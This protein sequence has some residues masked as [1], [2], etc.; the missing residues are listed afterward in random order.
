MSDQFR[1]SSKSASIN[2][3]LPIQ[4]SVC[5]MMMSFIQIHSYQWMSQELHI[6]KI[7][8]SF[9]SVLQILGKWDTGLESI[10]NSRMNIIIIQD[11]FMMAQWLNATWFSYKHTKKYDYILNYRRYV[12]ACE[13]ARLNTLYITLFNCTFVDFYH[14]TT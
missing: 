9:N 2:D 12:P 10:Y 11:F 8:Y 6:R 5:L 13:S 7:S 1:K 4:S 3:H 14:R